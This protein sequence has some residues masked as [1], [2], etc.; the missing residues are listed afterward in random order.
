MVV[1]EKDEAETLCI[2]FRLIQINVEVETWPVN[3][4]KTSAA[5][6]RI[7]KIPVRTG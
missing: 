7:K 2:A 3:L 4:P 5:R 6:D 1:Y